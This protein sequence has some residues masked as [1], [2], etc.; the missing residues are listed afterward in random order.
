MVA[1]VPLCVISAYCAFVAV[2][3]NPVAKWFVAEPILIVPVDPERRS[4]LMAVVP[5]L[6]R[7]VFAPLP[8][9]DVPHVKLPAL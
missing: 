6:E 3:K 9:D 8:L 4:A 7:V 2:P 1:S 5:R